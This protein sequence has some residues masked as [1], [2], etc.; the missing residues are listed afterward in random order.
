MCCWPWYTSSRNAVVYT[1]A[2]L[3]RSLL[4]TP[5]HYSFLLRGQECLLITVALT[6]TLL[7]NNLTTTIARSNGLL[8]M[9]P[10]SS[11]RAQYLMD[12]LFSRHQ[13]CHPTRWMI[14]GLRSMC[15]VSRQEREES[16]G[17]RERLQ[18]SFRSYPHPTWSC[19]QNRKYF[20]ACMLPVALSEHRWLSFF[21]LCRSKVS[22]CA[23]ALLPLDQCG[24]FGES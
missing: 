9:C 7:V 5:Y 20:Y 17:L 14:Y 15:G 12:R 2:N 4:T 24:R 11:S 19:Q 3:K 1:K 6:A 13:T 21:L 8:D 22:P 23:I 10:G 16:S 18:C